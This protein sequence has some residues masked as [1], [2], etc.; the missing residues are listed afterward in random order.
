MQIK[1]TT[2]NINSVR[3]RLPTIERFIQTQQPDILLLQEIKCENTQFPY[4][5]LHALGYNFIEV[6][7][8]KA[9]HG[10]ATLSRLPLTRLETHFCPHHEA[11]HLSTRVNIPDHTFELHNFYIPAG[12][13]IPDPD[14]NPKFAHKLDF[15]NTM[16][17]YFSERYTQGDARQILA[18]DFNIAPNVHDVWS[19]KQL[20]KIVSHTPLEVDRL[21]ALQTCHDFIDTARPGFDQND[22][23]KLYSWWSYRARDVFA[24]NRGRRLDHI[25]ISPALAP[26]IG[27]QTRQGFTI[28]HDCRIWDRP[29]DH[30]P[31]TQ[32]FNF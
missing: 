7:G 10:V 4:Q 9:Y 6:N 20:L 16:Q 17:A 3:L 22:G 18:G 12:G 21:A 28:H 14:T 5:D 15:L 13:D 23:E 8:Q 31:V 32:V 19:H 25:W 27:L 30:A 29:S 2:W 11:R 26:C 24:S 1:L